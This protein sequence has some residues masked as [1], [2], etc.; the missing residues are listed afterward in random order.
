MGGKYDMKDL[1]D[2]GDRGA[3]SRKRRLGVGEIYRGNR[4]LRIQVQMIKKPLQGT[5][6]RYGSGVFL[7]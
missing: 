1:S 2:L 4:T 5:S 6:I 7:L 3:E